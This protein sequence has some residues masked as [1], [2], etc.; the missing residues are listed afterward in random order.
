MNPATKTFH[1]KNFDLLKGSANNIATNLHQNPHPNKDQI[2]NLETSFK[3]LDKQVKGYCEKTPGTEPVK[4][5][6]DKAHAEWQKVKTGKGDSAK[7]VAELQ[8]IAKSPY[9]APSG[10]VER[11]STPAP[12]H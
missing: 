4:T 11:P 3:A 12:N 6:Y 10:A 9:V 2:E 5:K 8:W 1:A 7:V